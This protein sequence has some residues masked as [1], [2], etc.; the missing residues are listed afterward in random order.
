M[1]RGQ[2]GSLLGRELVILTRANA[3]ENKT[4]P[5]KSLEI[6]SIDFQ[7]PVDLIKLGYLELI[8]KEN[9]P[10]N[11]SYKITEKGIKYLKDAQDFLNHYSP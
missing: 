6:E 3:L 10:K 8:D 2:S 7:D 11:C 1:N 5:I 9:Y 4:V